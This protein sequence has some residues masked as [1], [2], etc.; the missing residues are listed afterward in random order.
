MLRGIPTAGFEVDSSEPVTIWSVKCLLC[1]G[2]HPFELSHVGCVDGASIDHQV[3]DA[4]GLWPRLVVLHK[5]LRK[6]LSPPWLRD[7]G[8]GCSKKQETFGKCPFL[9]RYHESC[10][11]KGTTAWI[12]CNSGTLTGRCFNKIT[13]KPLECFFRLSVVMM[14][15]NC[16]IVQKQQR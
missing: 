9:A 15:V 11:G 5:Y 13:E 1:D 2:T 7:N 16:S 12:M 4:S 3:V 10:R 8:T 14:V 6:E